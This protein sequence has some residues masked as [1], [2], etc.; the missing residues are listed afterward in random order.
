MAQ[1]KGVRR[2]MLEVRVAA[3]EARVRLLEQGEGM[4]RAGIGLDA[5]DADEDDV[6]TL[7]G[8]APWSA[9]G[10]ESS[11]MKPEPAED[12]QAEGASEDSDQ[13]RPREASDPP[14]K[15]NRKRKA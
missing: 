9:A 7:M 11:A 13:R 5:H 14:R 12:G 3:L 4:T 8:G 1:R 6:D 10:V 15:S 2:D